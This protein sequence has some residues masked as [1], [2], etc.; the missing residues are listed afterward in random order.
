MHWPAKCLFA[1]WL[2]DGKIGEWILVLD[3]VDDDELLR[4]PLETR[5]EPQESA[6]YHASTQSPLSYLLETS[7][8]AII[9]TSRDKAVA[10]KIAGHKKHLIDVQAM[11]MAEAI[12]LMQRKL[13]LYAESTE[14]LELVEELEFM[15]LAIIQATS[16]ITHRSP[17]CS[18]SQYLEKL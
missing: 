17:R 1:N 9:I 5:I 11:N 18:V 3:N 13:D 2:Q 12:L 6:Q 16:Y 8:G 14:L 15:P 10:L 4:K 7:T